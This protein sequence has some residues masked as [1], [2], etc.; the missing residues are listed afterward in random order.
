MFFPE[1]TCVQIVSTA[2]LA[3]GVAAAHS[4][5]LVRVFMAD[6]TSPRAWA[7]T[8]LKKECTTTVTETHHLVVKWGRA[9]HR[10]GGEVSPSHPHPSTSQYT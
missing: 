7:R 4:T 2:Q 3:S 1:E 6:T 9:P 8:N 10:T 5:I